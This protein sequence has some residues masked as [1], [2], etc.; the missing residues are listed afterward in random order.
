MI[1]DFITIEL[2]LPGSVG[3]LHHSIEQQ[4]RA[5][6]EP[7]RWA[8]TRVNSQTVEIEAVVTRE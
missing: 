8:I 7:L 5:F 6:G 2:T 3:E 1:T 4:L